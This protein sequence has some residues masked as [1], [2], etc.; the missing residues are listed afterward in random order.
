MER[1]PTGWDSNSS[2]KTKP[3]WDKIYY[4]WTGSWKYTFAFRGSWYYNWIIFNTHGCI[5]RSILSSKEVCPG[6]SIQRYRPFSGACWFADM[7]FWIDISLSE[8]QCPYLCNGDSPICPSYFPKM[9]HEELIQQVF[10]KCL[11]WARQ[12][13]LCFGICNREYDMT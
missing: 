11:L 9:L 2:L 13:Q 5:N 4:N 7:W 1:E 8:H 6:Y 10:I 12:V 3:K